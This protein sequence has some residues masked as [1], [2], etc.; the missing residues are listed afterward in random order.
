MAKSTKTVSKAASK[1]VGKLNK[2]SGQ[3]AASKKAAKAE[4]QG[5]SGQRAA[6]GQYADKRITVTAEG[7]AAN[8]RGHRGERWAV[9]KAAKNT[10]DVLGQTYTG[11]DGE[12]RTITSAS[13]S[14]FVERGFIT[15]S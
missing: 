7:K 3:K 11:A 14:N 13:L 8:P 9:V 12:P 2:A 1:K 10:N 5:Q 4:P 6:R 15:L